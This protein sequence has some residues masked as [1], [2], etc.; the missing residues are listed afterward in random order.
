[1]TTHTEGCGVPLDASDL[2]WYAA[3]IDSR[4][5][6][7][8]RPTDGQVLPMVSV[9]GPDMPLLQE[10]ARGTGVKVSEI[11]RAYSKSL[12]SEHCPEAHRHVVSNSGRWQLT[13]GRATVVLSACLPYIR[14]QREQA[15]R[16]LAISKDARLTTTTLG[17]MRALGWPVDS[18]KCGA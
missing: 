7:S 1:M 17:G 18:V 15:E 10:L 4:A 2:A 14:V 5:A 13:G 3:V 9:H 16:L 11:H 6:L 12:C 8:E